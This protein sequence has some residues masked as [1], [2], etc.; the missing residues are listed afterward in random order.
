MDLNAFMSILLRIIYSPLVLAWEIW[1]R[2]GQYI[3]D[4]SR[5]QEVY[6]FK[7]YYNKRTIPLQKSLNRQKSLRWFSGENCFEKT[8]ERKNKKC[9][10]KMCHGKNVW[11]GFFVE[12][13]PEQSCGNNPNKTN[14]KLAKFKTHN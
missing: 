4:G 5:N 9:K 2:F 6:E 3:N 12:C 13:N 10:R 7:S 1:A 14:Y 8:I 11:H